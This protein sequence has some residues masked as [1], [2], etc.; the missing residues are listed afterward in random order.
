MQMLYNLL[1]RW[2]FPRQQSW[3][4]RKNAKTLLWVVVFALVLGL[5]MAAVIRL[6]YNHTK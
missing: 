1:G 3:A 6:M 5:A 4:Q 2:L